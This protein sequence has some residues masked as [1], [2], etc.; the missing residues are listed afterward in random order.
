MDGCKSVIPHIEHIL[1]FPSAWML[2][3]SVTAFINALWVWSKWHCASSKPNQGTGS[4]CVISPANHMERLHIEPMKKEVSFHC[5]SFSWWL[6]KLDK[7]FLF[8][9]LLLWS[10]CSVFPPGFSYWLICLISYGFVNFY[11]L[12]IY[13]LS[14]IFYENYFPPIYLKFWPNCDFC[15]K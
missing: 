13:L 4:F 1:Y 15:L 2:A 14:H 12:W 9:Y 5:F 11:L 10:V 6:T 7:P 3:S 8:G